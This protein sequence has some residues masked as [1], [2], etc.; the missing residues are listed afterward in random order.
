MTATAQLDHVNRLTRHVQALPLYGGNGIPVQMQAEIEDARLFDPGLGTPTDVLSD[1]VAET[2][3]IK[4]RSSLWGLLISALSEVS[5]HVGALLVA[6]IALILS[7]DDAFYTG[8]Q[9]YHASTDVYRS[10]G[11]SWR[12]ANGTMALF[13]FIES[14]V[15]PNDPDW[16]LWVCLYGLAPPSQQT[17]RL[18]RNCRGADSLHCGDVDYCDCQQFDETFGVGRRC[19][20]I[21]FGYSRPT[22]HWDSIYRRHASGIGIL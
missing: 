19:C 4:F 7:G 9:C 11:W 14:Y 22:A 1:R 15:H 18:V 13:F 16:P 2:F 12:T 21:A 5:I 20:C 6:G 17:Y 10:N 8:L 3:S